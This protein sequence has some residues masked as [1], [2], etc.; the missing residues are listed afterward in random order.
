LPSESEI[1]AACEASGWSHVQ[2]DAVER[3]IKFD[4]SGIQLDF[5][6][7]GKGYIVDQAYEV[8]SDQ[9]V[10]CCLVDISGNMRVGL[11]PPGRA[12]WRIGISPLEPGGEFIRH[13]TL[14]NQAIA[15]S[16]D[17]WQ[18]TVIDGVRHSHILNPRTGYGVVGPIAAT[19]IAPTGIAADALATAACIL[20]FDQI[21]SIA[22]HES[23]VRVLVAKQRP[24][25]PPLVQEYGID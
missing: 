25:Y 9:G 5:G 24:G 16:G 8:L 14:N 20:E 7:I 1:A 6:G 4:Q 23:N 21:K 18:Y 11:P 15:T 3:T 19:V 10:T 13:L 17:L 2:L 22:Q 12:G